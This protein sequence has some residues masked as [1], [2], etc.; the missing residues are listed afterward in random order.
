MNTSNIR[1]TT[2]VGISQLAKK[3]RRE[4]SISHTKALGIASLQAGFPNF[5]AAK[6]SLAAARPQPFRVFLSAHWVVVRHEDQTGAGRVG[7]EILQISLSRPLADVVARHRISAAHGLAGFR[8]EYSDHLEHLTN[9]PSQLSARKSLVQAVRSLKF[10]EA[11]RLQPIT[12]AAQRAEIRVTSRL[13]GKDH[14]SQWFDPIEGGW[15]F[16]DE[17]YANSIEDRHD[18][19]AQWVVK[20]GLHVS[21]PNWEGIYYPGECEPFLVSPDPS[22]LKRVSRALERLAPHP[23]PDPWPY[24]TGLNGDDF[25]SPQRQADGKP[26]RPRPGP[27]Y[28]DHRGATPYGGGPGIRS[29]WR[30]AKPMSLHHHRQLAGLMQ[31]ILVIPLSTRVWSKLRAQSSRLEE[32]ALAEHR[33]EHGPSVVDNLY[34]GGSNTPLPTR[35]E[36]LKMLATANALIDRGY[37]DCKPRRELLAALAAATAEI[38][39][40]P[41]WIVDVTR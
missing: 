33:V 16:L 3:I 19:R 9:L 15:L 37:E 1:P 32:W 5:V 6:R 30:P 23:H 13:P 38:S 36:S 2:I 22:L 11:T 21:S 31:Q 12:T 25:V 4:L 28:R 7:R 8:M 17:P 18:D 35:V 41:D 39:R 10:M 20:H 29:Q 26:R 40:V 14:T 34:F 24:E 27:S